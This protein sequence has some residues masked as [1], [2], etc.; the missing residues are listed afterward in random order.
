VIDLS[1]VVVDTVERLA[2]L[3]QQTGITIRVH[4]LPELTILGD[5]MYLMQLLTNLVEN[6]LTYSS[7]IG[8]HVDIDLVCQYKQGQA[9]A[10]LRI[11]DN[12]PGI[13]WIA[14]VLTA[15]ICPPRPVLPAAD[16][17]AMDWVSPSPGGLCRPT[18]VKS[19]CNPPSGWELPSKSGS[20]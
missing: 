16:H 8:T 4:P 6:A 13:A 15:K 3:A 7:G 17:Q 9:W 11:A 18:T 5:R 19:V 12:G 2:P 20:P 14:H 1:D 10:N